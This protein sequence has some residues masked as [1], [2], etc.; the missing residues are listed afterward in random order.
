MN[1]LFSSILCLLLTNACKNR[2]SVVDINSTSTENVSPI[3][4]SSVYATDILT[5]ADQTE[6]WLPLIKGKYISCVVNQTSVIGKTHLVDS[7]L[8]TGVNVVNIFAPEHG[9]RGTEDAGATILNSKDTKTGLQVISLYGSNKKP[10]WNDIADAE[11]I[12]FDIQDVGARFYTY[13]STLHYVMEACAENKKQ[14]IILDRPNPNGF[15]VDGPVL[16]KEFSSFVGMHPV[17]IVHGMTIGEYAQMINGEK[18]LANGVQCDLIVIPCKNYDHK[19]YYEVKIPP[20]PNLKSMKAIYLYPSLCLF[21]GTNVS[22]GRGTDNP[23]ELFGSPYLE[24]YFK[25]NITFTPITKPGSKTPPFMNQ[26]CYGF[27]YSK[28]DLLL[29]RKGISEQG[30]GLTDL[31]TSYRSFSEKDKF[32]LPNNFFNKLAGNDE[33]MQQLKAGLS[34]GEI[35]LSWQDDLMAFKEIRKKYLLYPDFE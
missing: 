16:E 15:Y 3:D 13:I 34:V 23:F 4:T 9:F 25:N 8:S 11:I 2:E 27:E 35:Q 32:F 31:I 10:Q 30:L 22:V 5:G 29:I 7:I 17:P 14:L 33:L 1:I 28:M 12:I 6:L 21:E 24:K 20:S 18:W 26:Q 19:K